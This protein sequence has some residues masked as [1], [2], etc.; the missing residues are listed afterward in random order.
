MSRR[1][2]PPAA[3]GQFDA[4]P[5]GETGLGFEKMR[6]GQEGSFIVGEVL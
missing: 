5:A 4:A 6:P 2:G 1:F 3:I